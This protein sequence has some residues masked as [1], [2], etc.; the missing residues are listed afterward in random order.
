MDKRAQAIISNI[1]RTDDADLIEQYV[2]SLSDEE[3]EAIYRY[4][5]AAAYS[6]NDDDL[7]RLLKILL[8]LKRTY[9]E[10]LI[11]S[12][13]LIQNKGVDEKICFYFMNELHLAVMQSTSNDK[14]ENNT[15]QLFL[16]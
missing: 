5:E 16:D 11:R 9:G 12:L 1:L 4:F 2:D 13:R 10:M 15:I 6:S 8:Q 14:F 3:I 7:I